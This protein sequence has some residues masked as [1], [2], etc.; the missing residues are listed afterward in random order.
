MFLKVNYFAAGKSKGLIIRSFIK[1]K[2]IV[3]CVYAVI[4]AIYFEMI[5][6]TVLSCNS[7]PVK[8]FQCNMQT[9]CYSVR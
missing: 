3:F 6:Y 5:F 7:F 8:V 2:M 4:H 1:A 9:W